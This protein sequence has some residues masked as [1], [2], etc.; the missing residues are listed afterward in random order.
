MNPV[1]A[2]APRYHVFRHLRHPMNTS[3]ICLF[4]HLPFVKGESGKLSHSQWQV[5]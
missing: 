3:I 1:P 5:F 2:A 4:K